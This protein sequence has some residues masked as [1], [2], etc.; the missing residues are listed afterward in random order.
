MIFTRQQNI[1]R[2]LWVSWALTIGIRHYG[3][4]V[5]AVILVIRPLGKN[6]CTTVSTTSEIDDDTCEGE[7]AKSYFLKRVNKR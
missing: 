3:K 5:R 1:E 6:K 2:A 7:I 4:P